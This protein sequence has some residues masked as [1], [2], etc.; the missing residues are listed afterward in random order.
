MLKLIALVIIVAIAAIL[1]YA[2]TKPD[3]LHVERSVSIKAAPDKIFALVNDFHNW[4]DWTPYNRKD[5]AMKKTF[6]GA[7]SGVGA[8]YAWE[9]NNQA[10]Q[11]SISITDA[12][13]H[14]KIAFNLDM[15]KPFEGH[16]KVT[17]SFK[18]N[19]DSTRITWAMDAKS[20]Y[21]A[22]VMSVFMDMDKMIGSDFE[23]GLA[24]LKTL[25]EK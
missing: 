17:F 9:G 5:P 8:I 15:L 4:N 25:A 16:N 10:G 23:F 6:S 2:A 3:G 22:K 11:G 20:A 18:A 13:P 1:I 7:P 19:G 12:V 14:T 21:I 24:K